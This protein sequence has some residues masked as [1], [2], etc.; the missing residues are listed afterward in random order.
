MSEPNSPAPSN[1]IPIEQARQR[2][3][4]PPPPDVP[5]GP[6][7]DGPTTSPA[8][9]VHTAIVEMVERKLGTLNTEVP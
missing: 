3:P 6:P 1:I 7:P 5:Q 9:P 2:R 4:S 8:L